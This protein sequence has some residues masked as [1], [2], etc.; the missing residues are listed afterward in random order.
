MEQQRTVSR[1][2]LARSTDE[3]ARASLQARISLYAMLVLVS[4][5]TEIALLTTSYAAYPHIKPGNADAIAAAGSL[6]LIILTVLWRG[7]I[8]RRPLSVASLQ[9]IDLVIAARIGAVLPP[10]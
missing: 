5:V 6:G 4:I 7:V 10:G 1:T 3:E 8:A 9:R 2:W